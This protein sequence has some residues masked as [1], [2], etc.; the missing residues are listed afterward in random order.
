M[1][2]KVRHWIYEMYLALADANGKYGMNLTEQQGRQRIKAF[3]PNF[4]ELVDPVIDASGDLSK[5]PPELLQRS[6]AVLD[7]E[8]EKITGND[9]MNSRLR[10]AASRNTA[11]P[12]EGGNS[13]GDNR[14]DSVN[15][16][17]RQGR[18]TIPADGKS[19][20]VNAALRRRA[21]VA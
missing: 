9:A 17:L 16:L 10:D 1:P 4:A 6:T 8:E 13:Q 3:V 11:K 18:Q 2:R 5:I 15:E 12:D 19:D 14:A 20:A 21:G 7:S